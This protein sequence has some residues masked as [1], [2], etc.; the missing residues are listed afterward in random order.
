MAAQGNT[1]TYGRFVAGVLNK[2]NVDAVEQFFAPQFLDHS[3]AAMGIEGTVAGFK[4][5]FQMFHA[6]FPDARWTIEY[7]DD[8]GDWVYHHKTVVGTHQGEYLGVE[9]TG[10]TIN[11]QE[12]GL[13]RF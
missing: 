11:S 8:K 9:A 13:I 10:K 6:A 2:K 5:W 7:I 12:T 1:S 4:E 3:L